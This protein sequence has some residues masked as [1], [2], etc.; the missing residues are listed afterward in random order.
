MNS[1]S[2][3]LEIRR[4]DLKAGD[5]LMQYDQHHAVLQRANGEWWCDCTEWEWD[6]DIGPG[7]EVWC[8][9]ICVAMSCTRGPSIGP[10]RQ[11]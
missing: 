6:C 11:E 7:G 8:T 2:E 5:R 10:A 9:K 1:K 3:T 4:G